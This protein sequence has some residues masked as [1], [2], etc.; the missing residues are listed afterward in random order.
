[1]G[2]SALNLRFIILYPILL[3]FKFFLPISVSSYLRFKLFSES[4]PYL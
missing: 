3:C 2:D 4:V 1:M